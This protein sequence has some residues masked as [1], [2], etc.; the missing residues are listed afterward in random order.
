MEDM[1]N[2]SEQEDGRETGNSHKAV[3][4]STDLVPPRS[5]THSSRVV[6]LRQRFAN[7]WMLA[8]GLLIAGAGAD[9]IAATAK[10][11]AW[12]Q[13]PGTAVIGAGLAVLVS[14]LTGQR[15]V[16]EQYH[17]EANLQRK[18]DYYAPLHTDVKSALDRFLE[19]R[20]GRAGYPR[21][22]GLLLDPADGIPGLTAR[23]PPDGGTLGR[24]AAFRSDSRIDNFNARGREL[25][26]EVFDKARVYNVAAGA[27]QPSLEQIL[28]VHMTQAIAETKRLRDYQLWKRNPVYMPLPANGPREHWFS[29]LET[30]E[31]DEDLGHTW[32]LW[33]LSHGA[34]G[35]HS[36][37]AGWLLAGRPEIAGASLHHIQSQSTTVSQPLQWITRVLDASWNDL[38]L[39]QPH[40]DFTDAAEGLIN[41]LART[42]QHLAHGLRLIRDR[43]E[44]GEP[45]V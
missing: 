12:L 34:T 3:S 30:A 20:S 33:W 1:S 29:L 4:Q 22:V 6:R 39:Q 38:R 23:T 5:R 10:T 13:S 2:F 18:R 14:S 42:E 37:V 8:T 15:A 28:E 21:Q 31:S 19:V 7:L 24:W 26:D 40:D 41:A 11:A 32:T 35:H 44:G 17:K 9:T 43:Y 45:L 16:S 27:V 36:V 25:L